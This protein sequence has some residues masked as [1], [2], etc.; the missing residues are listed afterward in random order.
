[1]DDQAADLPSPTAPV[2]A[3]DSIK[4][5]GRSPW[6]PRWLR[7]LLGDEFFQNVRQVSLVYDDSTGKR[8]DNS[9]V[10][11]CA[12]LLKQISKLPGLMVLLLQ[13]TQATDEGL[14]QTGKMAEVEELYIWDARS[15]TDV[16]VSHLSS[17]NTLARLKGKERLKALY[18][19][20]GDSRI[21][22]AGLAHLNGYK[23]LE[24]LDLQN[25][26][27]TTWGL[28]QLKSLPNL[29]TLWLGGT[30]ISAVEVQSLRDAIPNLKMT[31]LQ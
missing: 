15:V 25:S 23:K 1:L 17:L 2:T 19:G 29:K 3:G 4:R 8:F 9:N 20:L 27:V 6:V 5:C 14:R 31:G 13:S 12:D 7:N 28:Q 10:R 30:S 18:I 11:A 16:G 21:T 22:D 24:I 26:K